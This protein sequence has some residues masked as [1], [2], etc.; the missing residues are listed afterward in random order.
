MNKKLALFVVYAS[1]VTR[2]HIQLVLVL[3]SLSMLVLGV[4]APSSGGDVGR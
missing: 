1:K 3:I 4:G 2:Q